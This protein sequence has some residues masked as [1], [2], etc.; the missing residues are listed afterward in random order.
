VT[1]HWS[2]RDVH[3]D[4]ALD[5]AVV[6]ST[7][8]TGNVYLETRTDRGSAIPI[9]L[10]MGCSHEGAWRLEDPAPVPFVKQPFRGFSLC[11]A[12][13]AAICL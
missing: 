13:V 11:L 8:P 3:P 12:A 7:I 4:R 9:E 6:K 10:T 1:V 5:A 2:L